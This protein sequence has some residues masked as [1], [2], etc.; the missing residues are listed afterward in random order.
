VDAAGVAVRK[1]V[2]STKDL[3]Y[4]DESSELLPDGHPRRGMSVV[5]A[6]SDW[7]VHTNRRAAG[8]WTQRYEHGIPVTDL[9]PIESDGST[10]TTVHFLPSPGLAPVAAIPTNFGD[11]L[12]VT[13]RS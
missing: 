2:M 11:H 13:V 12:A 4:F 10:G 3:R 9:T 6:L 8:S 7:L 1:P 5:S